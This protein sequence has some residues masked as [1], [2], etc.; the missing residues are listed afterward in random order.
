MA[1]PFVAEIRIFTGNFA[2]IGWAMCNGQL[3]PISQNTAL[4]SLLGTNFGGNGTTNFALPNL[5]GASP[6]G[7]GQGAGLSERNLGQSG[8]EK[9]VT[10][11]Q[12]QIPSH[13]HRVEGTVGAI[14]ASPSKATFASASLGHASAYGPST[15]T[16]VPMNANA[17]ET[18]GGGQ[19]HDNMP[20]YLALNFIISLQGIFPPRS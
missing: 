8:G 3:I 19:P 4:F 9:T 10:L 14:T 15:G 7:W 6:L 12:S 5:Q 1:D 17:V 13:S 20:P 11:T 16:P 2:P 18:S